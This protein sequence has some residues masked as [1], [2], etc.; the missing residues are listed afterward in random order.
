MG[1]EMNFMH[2]VLKVIVD[3]INKVS[4]MVMVNSSSLMNLYIKETLIKVSYQ[5]MGFVY[6]LQKITKVDTVVNGAKIKCTV[7]EFSHFQTV[8]F[9]LALIVKV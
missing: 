9:I 4:N 1:M 2:L 5:D 3:N 8:E 7:K 6:G